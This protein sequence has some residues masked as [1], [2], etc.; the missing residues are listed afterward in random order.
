MILCITNRIRSNWIQI[1]NGIY[2][3][4]VVN[5]HTGD[6]QNVFSFLFGPLCPPTLLYPFASSIAGSFPFKRVNN[7][8]GLRGKKPHHL[9]GLIWLSL[10]ADLQNLNSTEAGPS[11]FG[12][13]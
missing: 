2:G 12:G 1:G 6:E 13:L 4:H 7:E 5:C 11:D 8:D 9:R 3:A 10:T